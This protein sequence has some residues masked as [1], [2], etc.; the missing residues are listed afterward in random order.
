MLKTAVAAESNA[1]R[2]VSIAAATSVPETDPIVPERWIAEYRSTTTGGDR[3]IVEVQTGQTEEGFTYLYD[4]TTAP[5]LDEADKECRERLSGD[6][7][8]SVVGM[9]PDDWLRDTGTFPDRANQRD[10][11][12]SFLQARLADAEDRD[13][14]A[15][16]EAVADQEGQHDQDRRT[17]PCRRASYA[18]CWRRCRRGIDHRR[19]PSRRVTSRP[20]ER[21][22]FVRSSISYGAWS[23]RA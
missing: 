5:A 16:E 8:D 3:G 2:E 20:M 10:A 18:I 17:H 11:Y 13:L 9:I 21:R 7:I 12:R 19:R 15:R 23:A 4:A 6:V 22:S 1:Q 14:G